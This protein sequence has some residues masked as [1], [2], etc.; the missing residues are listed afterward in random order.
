[1]NRVSLPGLSLAAAVVAAALLALLAPQPGVVS[2][3]RYRAPPDGNAIVRLQGG[4]GAGGTAS[5]HGTGSAPGG[6]AG[7]RAAQPA[8]RGLALTAVPGVPA[9]AHPSAAV[10]R[11]TARSTASS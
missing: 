6:R 9:G 5:G 2:P 4:Q 1:M 11:A 7:A 10:R 8:P 3:G